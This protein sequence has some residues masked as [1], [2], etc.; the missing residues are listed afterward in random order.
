MAFNRVQENF[1]QRLSLLK[2]DISVSYMDNMFHIAF[3]Q[4]Q[5]G[6]LSFKVFTKTRVIYSYD[7]VYLH[8]LPLLK[9]IMIGQISL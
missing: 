6:K 4:A 5:R 2:T 9:S 3:L 1:L 8:K 7:Q